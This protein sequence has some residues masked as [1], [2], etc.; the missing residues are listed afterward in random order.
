MS[1]GLILLVVI[2]IVAF[3]RDAEGLVSAPSSTR[4]ED[5]RVNLLANASPEDPPLTRSAR[6]DGRPAAPYAAAN[7]GVDDLFYAGAYDKLA[8]PGAPPPSSTLDDG[9]PPA[10][11][12]PDSGGTTI[13]PVFL[14]ED[15]SPKEISGRR[16]D[17]IYSSAVYQGE[18]GTTRRVTGG[19]PLVVGSLA[20]SSRFRSEA[21]SLE[22]QLLNES[23]GQG[24]DVLGLLVPQATF[25]ADH[26]PLT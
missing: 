11:G 8:A 1:T 19:D 16:W 5:V 2:L 13:A 9:L 20:D 17:A 22:A 15:G 4:P 21:P 7:G 12:L 26:E 10:W 3:T 25:V 23:I 24:S 18:A 14:P 6:V